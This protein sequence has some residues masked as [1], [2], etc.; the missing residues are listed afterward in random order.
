MTNPSSSPLFLY[1]FMRPHACPPCAPSVGLLAGFLSDIVSMGVFANRGS[2]YKSLHGTV[3]SVTVVAA[4]LGVD[5]LE[6]GVT[7]GLRL[8][9][10]VV[11]GDISGLF[12]YCVVW[13]S[14]RKGRSVLNAGVGLGSSPRITQHPISNV[15][16]PSFSQSP[17]PKKNIRT[18]YGE[19]S[20]CCGAAMRSWTLHK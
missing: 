14:P 20:G 18:R 1:P 2:T 19:P 3:E 11:E 6:R 5:T 16:A 4:E 15:I 12:W 8:L 13:V 17:K 9:D 10:T 7:L